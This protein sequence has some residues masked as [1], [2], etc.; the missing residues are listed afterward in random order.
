MKSYANI[1]KSIFV[2]VIMVITATTLDSCSK[3][4][5]NPSPGQG[6]NE[7]FIQNMSFN[8]ATITVTVNT[9]VKWTNKDAIAHTVTSD[10]NLFDSGNINSNGTYS[11]QF[12]TAGTF[13][14]HCAIHPNMTAKV[15]VQ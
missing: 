6:S 3:S 7:V 4:S 14:Y 15:V 5:S 10:A 9:T 8:P 13:N 11:H 2:V 12:T 1:W